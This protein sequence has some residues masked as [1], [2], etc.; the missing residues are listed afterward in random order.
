M[1]LLSIRNTTGQKR[2][3]ME[4]GELLTRFRATLASIAGAVIV[5]GLE[6]HIAF[7]NPTAERLTGWAQ[8]SGARIMGNVPLYAPHCLKP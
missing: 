6:T 5:A 4:V 1:I 2:A 7:M 8:I 3:E